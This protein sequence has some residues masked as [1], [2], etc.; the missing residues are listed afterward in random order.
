MTNG[1]PPPDVYAV[2]AGGIDQNSVQ[3]IF[4]GITGVMAN[5]IQ[6]AGTRSR[7][8]RDWRSRVGA[9][10]RVAYRSA[11]SNRSVRIVTRSTFTSHASERPR[12]GWTRTVQL[13]QS[14]VRKRRPCGNR[15][16]A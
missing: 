5:K 8:R 6:R 12:A 13:P 15:A 9:I 11:R 3:R 10:I 4:Q 1:A 14:V 7:S 2:F 16:Q